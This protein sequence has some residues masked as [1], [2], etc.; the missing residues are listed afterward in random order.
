MSDMVYEKEEPK[1][2]IE[3]SDEDIDIMY[4]TW[5]EK[6]KLKETKDE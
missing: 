2:A 4:Q 5:L 3:L 1:L 6:Q